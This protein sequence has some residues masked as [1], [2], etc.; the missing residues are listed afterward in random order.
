MLRATAKL[1]TSILYIPLV[2]TVV[3]LF[4]CKGTWTETGLQCFTG[5]HLIVC[6]ISAVI[7]ACFS[8]FSFVGG[9]TCGAIVCALTAVLPA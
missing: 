7:I 9:S 2:S 1:S 4:N 6:I 5:V 3:R 8:F